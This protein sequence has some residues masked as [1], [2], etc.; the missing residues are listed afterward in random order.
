[1]VKSLKIG[2]AAVTLAVLAC[3]AIR[4]TGPTP[5]SAESESFNDN[6]VKAIQKIVKD[7]LLANPE[8]LLE[9]QEA[10]EKKVDAKRSEAQRSRMPELYKSLAA[11]KTELA[12]FMVG[13][14]DVTM[15]EFFDYNC[16]Y[17][18]RALSDVV[19]LIDS[20]KNF[21]TLFLEY[22]ILSQG[23]QE[24]SKVAVA[25]AKQGKYFEF[26]KAML[27]AGHASKES[28]LKVAEKL[29]L[30]MDKVKADVASPET[31]ALI[32]KISEIGRRSFIDGTP[33]FIVGDQ[34]SPGVAD[35]DQLKQLVEETR[36]SGCKACVTD[37]STKDGA[38]VKDEKKS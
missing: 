8:V 10:Y 38:G 15:I 1:M 4:G 6:Q 25:A 30:D 26:H 11:M 13:S 18:Q 32:A 3:I 9:V 16:P 5:A 31:A 29:G 2:V 23:S 37:A 24:A 34:T 12:P 14:G 35:F 27:T 19:K 7:Y 17:C 36:K 22:P 33:S 20:D 28:A 21:K